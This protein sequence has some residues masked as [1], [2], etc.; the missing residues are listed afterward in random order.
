[1]SSALP[2]I[3]RVDL[4]ALMH[5]FLRLVHT[6]QVFDNVVIVVLVLSTVYQGVHLK[7]IRS[8]SCRTDSKLLVYKASGLF[9]LKVWCILHLFYL[10]R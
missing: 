4:F 1:M 2:V 8:T 6:N 5:C 9:P 10:D 7:V 3:W